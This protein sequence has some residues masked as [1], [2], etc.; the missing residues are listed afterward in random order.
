MTIFVTQQIMNAYGYQGHETAR[1]ECGNFRG[2]VHCPQ[3]GSSQCYGNKRGRPSV[4][5]PGDS[6]PTVVRAFR[7]KLCTLLFDETECVKACK[8]QTRWRKQ[9]EARERAQNAASKLPPA[10]AQNLIDEMR[11]RYGGGKAPAGA[12]DSTD[13]REDL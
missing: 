6:Q 5:F 2:L 12:P 13:P 7:C 9:T 1:C 11:K 3:C 8:A 4:I 10:A